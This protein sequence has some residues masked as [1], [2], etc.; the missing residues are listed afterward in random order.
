M[1]NHAYQASPHDKCGCTSVGF[2]AGRYFCWCCRLYRSPDTE[3][4]TRNSTTDKKC[5]IETPHHHYW[6]IHQLEKWTDVVPWEKGSAQE[7]AEVAT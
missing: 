6:G 4:Q 1:A 7:T 5:D 3:E 2:L